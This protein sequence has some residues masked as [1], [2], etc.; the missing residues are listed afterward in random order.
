MARI[1]PVKTSLFRKFLE[2]QGLEFKRIKGDHEIWK[3]PKLIRPVTFPNKD[4]EVDPF[5]IESNLKTLQMEKEEFLE[6][7]KTL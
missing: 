1:T 7:I 4:K 6:I 3:R 5:V 2:L